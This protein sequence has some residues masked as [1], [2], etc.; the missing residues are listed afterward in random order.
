MPAQP[1][2]EVLLIGG[3]H[4]HVQV[5]RRQL[6]SPLPG[7]RLTMVV[8]RPVA[9][10]S[11]MVPG[12]VAGQYRPEE[13]DIDL[14]P[15]ARKAGARLIVAAVTGVDAEARRVH[16]Q[17][18]PPIAYDLASI[19]VGSTVAGKD[20]PGVRA[21]AVPT[22]PIGR[23]V[24]RIEALLA[25]PRSGA[26]RV[27][28]VGAGAGGV[29]LAFCARERLL[30]GGASE[31]QVTLLDAGERVLAGSS[32]KL[33][34]HVERAAAQRGIRIRHG[35]RVAEVLADAV[36]LEGGERL[37]SELTLWVTGAAAFPFLAESGLPTER[38]FVKVGPT[39]Q[40]LGHPELFAVGDCNHLTHAP[41]TPKAGVYAVRE[42]PFL[43]DN[44]ALAL[45]GRPLREY[46]PQTDFL[47]LLNLGDGSALG[48]KWGLT[49]EGAWVFQLKDRID[50][51]FMEKFQVLDAAGAEAEGFLKGMPPMAQMEM[52][53]GG[54][55][56]KVGASALSRALARLPRA[57]HPGVVM[58][59][60]AADDAAAVQRP[61]EVAVHN[62]DAF[63][64]FTDDPWLVGRVAALNAL[65][66]LHAC[67]VAPA[68]AMALVTIP[69]D[70]EPEEALFQVLSGARVALDADGVVLIGGH[71]TLGPTLQV[72]FSVTG[73]V[74]S[75]DQLWRN[76]ALRAGDALV[77]TRGLGTGVLFHA[78]MAGR[79]SGP[80]IEA[81]LAAMLRGN[82]PAAQVAGA[83]GVT[84]V[85]DVTG[86][87]LAGHLG[88]MLRGAGLS[89]T[90]ALAA[91]PALPG[92]ERLIRAGERSTFHDQ[93]RE[94]LKALYAPERLATEPKLELLFDP[95]TAGG[96]LLGVPAERAEALVAALREAGEADAAV[97]GEVQGPREDGALFALR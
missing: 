49:A 94:A 29:E 71:T 61:G 18:R 95:Q 67:G 84:G 17:G 52:V 5:L 57:E 75:A 66:D 73:Y 36:R 60:E 89:A 47:A 1:L 37:P 81:A 23:F 96:L 83:L 62:V 20:L 53:C 58:G 69:E 11:G 48:A 74:E 78:D 27:V 63:P 2:Q 10:Y 93:N 50:R 65:S 35:T 92:A 59:L 14:R 8:D 44:L 21:H 12:V 85:T 77:L 64:A 79:A 34:A 25:Q 38:G 33:A 13:V 55:A 19:N 39:L 87:G 82:G 28:V 6:M 7:A 31:V 4:S 90:V 3:G 15:L 40:V 41:G 56:A 16:V 97:I 45:Q 22:R 76:A 42:G 91:V 26:V 46:H 68:H 70:S 86:F 30:R 54:C 9:A 32:A 72:G 24:Q 80:E 51:A 43:A 88:E